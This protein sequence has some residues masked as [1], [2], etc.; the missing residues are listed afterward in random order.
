MR[1]GNLQLWRVSHGNAHLASSRTRRLAV[2][3]GSGYRDIFAY[4]AVTEFGTI[5]PCKSNEASGRF[6]SFQH[7]RRAARGS[8]ADFARFLL[9]A[10]GSV[11]ELETQLELTER[12]ELAHVDRGIVESLQAIRQMLTG[13]IRKVTNKSYI[14]S[15]RIASRVSCLVSRTNRR[16]APSC[17]PVLN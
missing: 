17:P 3:D 15:L 11:A 13:L 16:Q 9:I 1:R 12:L 8:S 6:S 7:R 14:V 10:R 2:V 4:K 5:R